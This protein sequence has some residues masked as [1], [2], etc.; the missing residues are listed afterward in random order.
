MVLHSVNFDNRYY[1]TQ[2]A[3][4]WMKK[5]NIQPIKRVHNRENFHSFRIEPP[6]ENA[7]YYSK[8][9]SKGIYMVFYD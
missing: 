5:H 7:K 9:V 2:D 6:K 3:H 8:Y 1:T 4:N